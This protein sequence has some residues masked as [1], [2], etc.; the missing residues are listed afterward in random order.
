LYN[1]PE[2][3]G[4]DSAFLLRVPK[5]K[6]ER[7]IYRPL[8]AENELNNIGYGIHLQQGPAEM[9]FQATVVVIAAVVAVLVST[10]IDRV[11]GGKQLSFP[12]TV[13]G[14]LWAIFIALLNLWKEWLKERYGMA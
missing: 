4:D 8:T 6:G 5:R 13:C 7:L 2:E 10:I 14:F 3:F 9:R 11:L 1:K 12:W